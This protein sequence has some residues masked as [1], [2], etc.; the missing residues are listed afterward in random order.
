MCIRDRLKLTA[1]LHKGAALDPT[2]LCARDAFLLATENG[3]AAQG[4][5]QECG[6]LAVG[7]DADLAMLDLDKPHWM[8]CH[9]LLS[10][11]VYAARGSDVCMTM[12]RGKILYENGTFPTIDLERTQHELSLIHI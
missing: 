1:I 9:N 2:V 10:N 6:K 7:L 11:V 3:A 4:R 8:P 5:E 12:V